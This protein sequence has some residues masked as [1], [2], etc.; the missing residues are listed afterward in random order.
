MNAID[1]LF[2]PLKLEANVF[3]NGQYRGEWALDTSGSGKMNF[4]VV[5]SGKCYLN[6]NNKLTTLTEGDA[7]FFPS[8]SKHV[9]SSLAD[10]VATINSAESYPPQT[11]LSE[12]STGLVC[13]N[14]G[15]NHPLFV[16]LLS[17]LPDVIVV[18]RKERSAASKIVDLIMQESATLD[19]VT[20]VLLNRLA[21][22]LFFSMVKNHVDFDA[23]VFAAL[24]HEKLSK[25][26]H[27]IHEKYDQKLTLDE[28]AEEAFMSR[29]AFSTLFKSVVGQ[30]PMDYLKQWRMM[31]AYRWLADEGIST[32]EAA[33]RCGYESESSFSKAFASVMGFGPGKARAELKA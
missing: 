31:L 15:H 6:V 23:G 5:V 9:I 19:T 24:V 32:Y 17:Q 13:G 18:H 33:L 12:P 10:N 8:D 26:M 3:H 14:F 4:H 25:P 29:S 28:L 21:D 20:S 27:S 2:S 1:Q 22:C 30:S 11:I 16:R 7:V